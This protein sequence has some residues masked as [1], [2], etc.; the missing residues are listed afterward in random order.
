VLVSAPAGFGKTTLLVQWLAAEGGYVAWISLE[1]S[2]SDLPRFLARVVDAFAGCIGTFGEEARA[3]LQ[4]DRAAT[5]TTVLSSLVT[6]LDQLAGP[7]RRPP[8]HRR[9]PA[10]RAQARR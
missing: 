9:D 10:L 2:D 3:L 7:T 6:D 4:S 8:R 1:P 5:A